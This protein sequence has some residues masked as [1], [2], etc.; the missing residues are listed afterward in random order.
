MSE[1]KH[2]LMNRP[3]VNTV[4]GSSTRIDVSVLVLTG[5]IKRSNY[6]HGL[7]LGLSP[8]PLLLHILS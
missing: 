4:R 3:W 2:N 6:S 1:H 5:F 7:Q 8:P